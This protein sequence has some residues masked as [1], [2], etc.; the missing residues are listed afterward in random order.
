LR[1][2]DPLDSSQAS[3]PRPHRSDWLYAQETRK[4][5]I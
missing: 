3:A 5:E 2:S 1:S 4:T